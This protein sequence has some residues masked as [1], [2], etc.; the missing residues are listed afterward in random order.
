[1]ELPKDFPAYTKPVELPGVTIKKVHAGPSQTLTKQNSGKLLAW[2]Q[3]NQ[4]IKVVDSSTGKEVCLLSNVPATISQL[5]L[6]PSQPFLATS[7][8]DGQVIV[9]SLKSK[10]RTVLKTKGALRSMQWKGSFLML[11]FE[12]NKV[13]LFRMEL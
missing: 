6:H 9:W 5:K 13:Q 4:K 1:M 11:Q 7:D 10:R 12:G 2:V 8:K 3:S